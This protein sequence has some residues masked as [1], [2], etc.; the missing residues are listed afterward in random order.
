LKFLAPELDHVAR[1]A[2]APALPVAG[3]AVRRAVGAMEHWKNPS[4]T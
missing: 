2:V 3:M 4:K 1:L